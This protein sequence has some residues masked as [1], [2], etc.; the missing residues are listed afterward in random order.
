M[1]RRSPLL[2]AAHRTRR[3]TRSRDASAVREHD[4]CA[5]QLAKLPN[6]AGLKLW[7]GDT[8]TSADGRDYRKPHT[9]R[10]FLPTAAAR[11]CIPYPSY[12]HS[13]SITYSEQHGRLRIATGNI[14]ETFGCDEYAGVTA[15]SCVGDTSAVG[16][17]CGCLTL[18]CAYV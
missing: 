13:I 15:A 5:S 18:N 14:D 4:P 9:R 10:N 12:N 1:S 6:R 16:E 8:V 3:A 17:R 7:W 2:T 11:A